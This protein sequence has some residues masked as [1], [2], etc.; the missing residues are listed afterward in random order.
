LIFFIVFW[1]LFFLRFKDR[2][3][4]KYFLRRDMKDLLVPPF[5]YLPLSS[6]LDTFTQVL[7]TLPTEGHAFSTKAR[8]PALML[9]ELEAHPNKVNVAT[10]LS[11][12]LE[13]YEEG[14]V[15][16]RNVVIKN[17]SSSAW[18]PEDEMNQSVDRSVDKAA[19]AQLKPSV[20]GQQASLVEVWRP[21]GTGITR[22]E[23]I[24]LDVSSLSHG[25]ASGTGSGTSTPATPTTPGDSLVA[26]TSAICLTVNG[27]ALGYPPD[28]PRTTAEIAAAGAAAAAAFNS[29]NLPQ[30]GNAPPSTITPVRTLIGETFAQKAARLRATSQYGHLPGWQLGGL[31]AKSNDDV[32]QEVFVMQLIKYYQ[33][34]FREANLP[35]W[36]FTYTILSTSQSTGLIE[37]IPDAVSLDGLKKKENYPGSLRKYFETT[38]GYV[39]GQPEPPAFREAISNY[40]ASMSAYSVVCYLLGIKDRHNGNVMIDI[41]GHIIHI[42]FG[43][44]FGLAPG[45]AFSMETA[46]WKLT[47]E[48][49]EVGLVLFFFLSLF[50]SLSLS[51]SCP[52]FLFLFFSLSLSC[53]CLAL[54]RLNSAQLGLTRLAV[55][56]FI[57]DDAIF[58]MST[59]F[60]VFAIKLWLEWFV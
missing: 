15:I 14:Q 41:H 27:K 45:K 48:M 10:F 32:R 8:C 3:V 54:S 51:L 39:K 24:G 60:V 20:L 58:N 12:E 31:I 30:S 23:H 57:L 33:T 17:G 6:S 26:A 38:Y 50:L 40:V 46:P 36:M 34:A 43:F 11:G 47:E 28:T 13:R 25:T 5:A 53:L 9:F 2:P 42:D 44:V 29:D 18:D 4:R 59:S 52:Y 22:L 16:D 19:A 55:V 1:L 7:C 56:Q 49:A 37:L 21:E 35:C